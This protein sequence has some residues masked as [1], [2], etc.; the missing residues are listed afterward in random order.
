MFAELN[1]SE[2]SILVTRCGLAIT[3]FESRLPEGSR[4]L[5][6]AAS[7]MK[8]FMGRSIKEIRGFNPIIISRADLPTQCPAA[9]N[10][11]FQQIAFLYCEA[12]FRFVKK[13]GC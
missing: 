2:T 13:I 8:R 11:N 9:Y 3:D 10:T 1:A 12:I 4:P 7:W 5:W 6:A